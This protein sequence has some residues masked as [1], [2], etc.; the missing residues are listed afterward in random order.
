MARVVLEQLT[1]VFAGPGG[2]HVQALRDLSLTIEDKEL[3]VLAGP[4]GCGKTTTL[5]LI[6]GLEEASAGTISIDGKVVNDVPARNRDVAMVF[7]NLALYPHMN[8][9]ENM[10][11][12]LKARK[13]SKAEITSR[14]E[15]AVKILDLEE[16]L[17]R[18]P[19]ELSGGQRQRVALGR[20]I[21]LRP[22]LLLLDEPLSNLDAPLRIRM[23]LELSALHDRLGV[24]MIYVTH[25]QIDAM[26]LGERVAIL[27]G[28]ELQQVAEPM[29]LYRR[30]ANVFVAGFFGSPP[31]NLFRGTFVNRGDALF[32][33]EGRE[34]EGGL[35]PFSLQIP[36]EMASRL[37]VCR[38]KSLMLGIRPE[39]I[40]LKPVSHN[41]MV[42][43]RL[44]RI[45]QLGAESHLHLRT[46]AHR[47]IARSVFAEDA[48]VP[49]DV[50]VGFDLQ[51]AHFFDPNT[52]DAI[53]DRPEQ[54]NETS[55]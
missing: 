44:E 17:N 10:A 14:I 41:G 45:E 50:Q 31:M 25:D 47:F 9:Y 5:R 27:R 12:G 55:A 34:G 37:S 6:A 33:E 43:A 20:A 24:T 30:P 29:T 2:R 15:D 32:F 54:P 46:A 1:K 3:L 52:G 16:C 36:A 4:S 7:Q 35:Q 22:K 48:A 19:S 23:R 49:R 38:S 8:A 51:S 39:N 18:K 53:G 13:Y 26:T 28:G 21:V 42:Q 40:V 11:F